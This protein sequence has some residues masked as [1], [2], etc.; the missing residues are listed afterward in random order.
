[1][2]PKSEL[3]VLPPP[4]KP[5]GHRQEVIHEDRF[6][7]RPYQVELLDVA[8]ERNTIVC[9]GTGKGK[10]FIG[11]MLMKMKAS[12]I[13]KPFDEGGKRTI[14]L[15]PTTP[16]VE[17]Q[18]KA[19]RYHTDFTVG[20]YIG[21][22]GVDLWT[23]EKWIEEFQKYQIL[24]MT[25]Q[26]FSDLLH[27][28]FIS[29]SRIN[30][31]IFDECHMAVK[32]HPY[33]N[34]M[35]F[36]DVCEEHPAILGLTAAILHSKCRSDSELDKT[37][38]NL[39]L[40]LRS[41]AVTSS[42]MIALDA[43]GTRPEEIL[44]VVDEYEDKTG[45]VREFSDWL[46][47]ALYFMENVLINVNEEDGEKDPRNLAKYALQ[48]C[49]WILHTLGPWCAAHVA[50]VFIKQLCCRVEHEHQE[51]T[52]QFIHMTL[53]ILRMIFNTFEQRFENNLTL[54]LDDFHTFFSP[55]VMELIKLLYAYK[56]DDDFVIETK[57][58]NS[59]LPE[60][61]DYMAGAEDISDDDMDG[62]SNDSFELSDEEPMDTS[63][64]PKF[65]AYQYVAKKISNTGEKEDGSNKEDDS[66]L[67]IVFV[68]RRH[69]AYALNKLIQEL[70]I[71][72]EKLYFVKSS[73]VMGHGQKGENPEAKMMQKKLDETMRKFRNKEIN[74]LISTSVLEE[75]LDVPK[76][77]LIVRF[78]L[79]STYRAYVQSK[80]RARSPKSKYYMLVSNEL[81]STFPKE[82]HIY[83]G[84]EKILMEKCRRRDE[85]DEDEMDEHLANDLIPPYIPFKG[86]GSPRVTM[87][88]AIALVNR[89]CAKLPSDAFTHLTPK[90][91]IIEEM[92]N[93]QKLFTCTLQL[94]IN[95]VVKQQ[96]VGDP[97]V[98]KKL[99][100]MSVALKTCKILHEANELDD[101]LL[102]VGKEVVQ[103]EEEN[104]W[105][106][107]AD[108]GISRTGTTRKKQNYYKKNADAFMNS[109][110]EP[111]KPSYLYLIHMVLTC[112][113]SEEQNTRGRK[114]YPPEEYDKAFGVLTA[115][116]IPNIPL[117]PVFTRS[118]EVTV[119]LVQLNDDLCHDEDQLKKL[120]NF[121]RYLFNRV[122][123]LEKDPMEYNQEKAQC[124]YLVIPIDTTIK[125]IDW[126]FV[127]EIDECR[128]SNYK[129]CFSQSAKPDEKFEF[130]EE[131]HLDAVVMP[132][133]R[134]LDKP[135]YFYVAEIR[136]DLSP[137]SHFPSQ[138]LYATF[139]DYYRSKY[140]LNVTNLNQPLLDVDHTSAR[141]NLLTPRYMNQK[142]VALPTS[143]AQT[144]RARR[145]NL[146]QKQI[147]I[148]ELCGIHPFPASLWRKTVCIPAILYRTNYL[149]I[150]NEIRCLIARE[151]GIGTENVPN[152]F[153]FPKLDFGFSLKVKQMNEQLAADEA[154]TE[155][156]QAN[157]SSNEDD[158]GDEDKDFDDNNDEDDVYDVDERN[159]VEDDDDEDD[160]NDVDES[161]GVED[162]D[163]EDNDDVDDEDDDLH[164]MQTINS[165]SADCND[166]VF[167]ANFDDE[168]KSTNEI[169]AASPSSSTDTNGKPLGDDLLTL[170]MQDNQDDCDINNCAND[171]FNTLFSSQPFIENKYGPS[172]CLILQTLTMSNANDFFNLERLETIGDSFLKFA[173][174]AYLYCMYPSIHEGKLSH[175]RSKQVS[176]INLFKLGIRKGFAECMVSTKFEPTENWLPSGYVIRSD[177]HSGVL[178]IP[179]DI[180]VW[181]PNCTKTQTAANVD[182]TNPEI[183]S[184]EDQ[185]K[186]FEKE[187]QEILRADEEKNDTT[188]PA[189]HMLIPYNLQTQHSLPKKSIADCVE[190]L[191]GCYLITCGM[192]D[193]LQF[194]SWLGLKVL[195]KHENREFIDLQQ[196]PSPLLTHEPNAEHRLNHM[197]DGFEAFEAK[198]NYTFKDRAYLLQA[199]THAS[200]HY[201]TITDCYQRLEFLGDAILDYVI[202]RHLFQDSKKH[203]PGVLTDLRSALVNNNIFAA[204]A[205][206]W[207]FHKYFKAVSPQL[208][209]VI[210]EFVQ[211]QKEK[212]NDEITVDEFLDSDSDE[213][214]E[215]EDI[216]I[217]KALGDIFESVAGAIYLDSG[218]DLE[219]VWKVYFHMMRPQIEMFTS[220][221][222]KSPV[223]ELLE[224]EPEAAKFEKPERTMD[225]K[226]RVTVN[227]MGKGTYTGVGRN[228]RIAKSAAAKRA[229]KA[230][231]NLKQ[232]LAN[233]AE[234]YMDM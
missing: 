38:R 130:L 172:P 185:K 199:F 211:W 215:E 144:K 108:H 23:G 65:P 158:N 174:T 148:P 227:V 56:P 222:P 101:R 82:L 41:V 107:D 149:L 123:R 85:H 167:G 220:N 24:V 147:F 33:V 128:N 186:A 151:A 73:H 183:G 152:D 5:K 29:L 114:L 161:N 92:I 45:L 153:S 111:G 118:G 71:W 43:F 55:K 224:L 44:I 74:L 221:I 125:G 106:D 145:E 170:R 53:T 86:E 169:H 50:K 202:T 28:G 122:L 103:Y 217:P 7:P 112:P 126:K 204:L 8:L 162:N 180:N 48:E 184:A 89:Y 115:K 27:H 72:D 132:A 195:P 208:F 209:H 70:C 47:D 88:S 164:S 135:Q 216:E 49:S 157:G 131:D 100:K 18:A 142:G 121:H 225:G 62:D 159:D 80:G 138:E 133:Y 58:I 54:T 26:I 155:V 37:I 75:G 34:I 46:D 13:R 12:A 20:N 105:E 117:F 232:N 9:L 233:V 226:I 3:P 230:L 139:E 63:N 11:I 120:T 16:M 10:T 187:L 59:E 95:S 6:T 190:A 57:E 194:M 52:R 42:D 113:I 140:G 36:H 4:R 136:T 30:L 154:K 203:S 14:F 200:F 87:A 66:M 25:P 17:Q 146:Q 176:N 39:E 156:D 78:D 213:S 79:P 90:C 93:G 196:P 214:S 110:P 231:K 206:K 97:M 177:C 160:V 234:D 21:A 134:N 192:K 198:I 67:G 189:D 84:I 141:L 81:Q 137:R 129:K 219:T 143:S 51:L 179:A 182:T 31:L 191:I 77:N 207:D 165:S 116:M 109:K 168:N 98:R 201:N 197:L 171:G 166:Y 127:D 2:H 91:R 150:A 60:F 228:Y 35:K 83:R 124:G 61:D 40:T 96:I 19:I 76:C 15:V 210:N 218:M 223:R 163:D 94:P 32:N 175:L 1:M 181:N 104:D 119:S 212:M 102:P 69:V 64:Q 229:L 22:L 178:R 99:A 173:I 68:E 193:A 205:V 188:I